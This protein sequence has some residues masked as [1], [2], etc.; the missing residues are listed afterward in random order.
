MVKQGTKGRCC[1]HSSRSMPLSSGIFITPIW[2]GIMVSCF[3][4]MALEIWFI[5]IFRAKMYNKE[6]LILLNPLF[7]LISRRKVFSLSFIARKMREN[8]TKWATI[9]VNKCT[10]ILRNFPHSARTYPQGRC[11]LPLSEARDFTPQSQL[12]M[13]QLRQQHFPFR[14]NCRYGGA[15]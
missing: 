1:E 13:V 9:V 14:T 12:K 6:N 8:L 11:F 2:P 15:I 10:I 5:R 7:R 4:I 3:S